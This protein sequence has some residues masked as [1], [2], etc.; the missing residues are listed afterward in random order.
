MEIEVKN[1]YKCYESYN[2]FKKERKSVIEDIS[3][4]LIDGD[5]LGLLGRNGAGKTTL[6]KIILGLIEPDEGSVIFSNNKKPNFGYANSNPRSFFWRISAIENLI[7]FG[8]LL[9]LNKKKVIDRINYISDMLEINQILHKPFMLLSSGQMQSINIA[10]ALLKK[11][12]VLLLDEPTTSLDQQGSQKIINVLRN[13]LI[14]NRIPAIWCSHDYFE[15]NRVCNKFGLLKNKK[16][17]IADS[18]VN[19][20]HESASNYEFEVKSDDKDIINKEYNTVDKN[21]DDMT[22]VF[23]VSNKNLSLHDFLKFLISADVTLLSIEKK[24]QHF[25]EYIS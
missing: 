20:F 22:F 18:E 10:R 3:F 2:F 16:L 8:R 24:F 12:D 13:Y 23:S 25:E 14:E 5:I 17:F 21:F 6:I 9:G 19:L 4:N 1:I 15:L 11:P 7:F